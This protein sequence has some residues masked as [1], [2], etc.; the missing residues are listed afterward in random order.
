VPI[1]VAR[2]GV[3]KWRARLPTRVRT[4]GAARRSASVG[5]QIVFDVSELRSTSARSS[6]GR[7]RRQMREAPEQKLS[8]CWWLLMLGAE[9]WWVV[10]LG[11]IS[12]YAGSRRYAN[13]AGCGVPFGEGAAD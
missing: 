9:H 7:S 5:P 6:S 13:D 3:E 11:I 2:P 12:R 4:L 1:D 10:R 8:S